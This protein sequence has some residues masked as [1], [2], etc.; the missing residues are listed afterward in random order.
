MSTETIDPQYAD[1]DLWPTERA[2]EAMLDGQIAAVMALKG[3][4][5]AIAAAADAASERLRRSGRLVYVGAGTSG[6]V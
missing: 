1:L 5:G 3:Q 4:S 2:V 6:R